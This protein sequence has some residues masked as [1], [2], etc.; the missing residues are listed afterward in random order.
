MKNREAASMT[1]P[2]DAWVED[3]RNLDNAEQLLHSAHGI[4]LETPAIADFLRNETNKRIVV[5]PKGYGKTFLLKSKRILLQ[6]NSEN[7]SCLPENQLVDATI[8]DSP[9]L[10]RADM[11]RFVDYTFWCQ[12]W[13]AALMLSV[14]KSS[15]KYYPFDPDDFR[16]DVI[17][18]VLLSSYPV[19]PFDALKRLINSDREFQQ[20]RRSHDLTALMSYYRQVRRPVAVFVDTIDEYFEGYVDRDDQSDADGSYLHRNKDSRIWIVG[21][22]GI[23]RAIRELLGVNPHV[24]IFVSIRKEAFNSLDYY[25]RNAVNISSL[26]VQLHYSADELSRIFDNNISAMQRD[27]LVQPREATPIVRFIGTSNAMIV[28]PITKKS[29]VCFDFMLR[30]SLYRPRDLMLI[31]GKIAQIPAAERTQE[32]IRA[33]VDQ[34]AGEIVWHYLAEMRGLTDIPDRLLFGLIPSN[35]LDRSALKRTAEEY[36]ARLKAK[37]FDAPDAHPFCALYRLGLL[38]VVRRNRE[39]RDIQ[40]FRRPHDIEPYGSNVT[41]PAERHYLIHPAL[42]DII[43]QA[44]SDYIRAFHTRNVIGHGDRWRE[45]KIFKCAAKGDLSR[46]SRVLNDPVVGEHFTRYLGSEFE[47]CK[48]EVEYAAL[49]SGDSVVLVDDSADRVLSAARSLQRAVRRFQVP[50][51]F[52]F[53]AAVGPIAFSMTDKN[54]L[55]VRVPSAGIVI[56]AAARI[57][58][59]AA[60]GTMLCSEEFFSELDERNRPLFTPLAQT[61]LRGEGLLLGDDGVVVIRKNDEEEPIETRLF[62][63]PLG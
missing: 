11:Q 38:G 48:N 16:S 24:K 40:I 52:R 3:A 9:S 33:A 31:G 10:S 63:A 57:E 21:Q 41:L 49:E 46:Y 34:A 32:R 13:S 1:N 60:P 44:S 2:P 12:V 19:S 53:G 26:V 14:V 39:Q 45:G 17:R 47:K 28:N 18:Q 27:E 58:P 56:R 61:S 37:A 50:Q 54:G 23:C 20:A 15:A 22:L 30:H 36:A 62:H 35:V 8:S 29:E 6:R 5:A 25:D 4:L 59:H 55:N 51:D 7:L 42:D 43:A